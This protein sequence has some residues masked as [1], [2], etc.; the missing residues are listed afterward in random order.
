MT[1]TL[2]C[3]NIA[4]LRERARRRLPRGIWEYLERGVEDEHGMARNRAA[5]DA[6]TFV[7]RVM[8]RVE[9]IDTSASIFGKPVPLPL[10]IAPTGAAGLIWHKGDVHLARAAA[11]A[12]VP[13]TI[14][15][16]GTMDIEEIV[17]AGGTQW[18]Q[19]Y[20][21][22]DKDL[23][24]DVVRR[25]HLLG[26]EA[27]FVT[28]D[29]PVIPNREYLHRNGY[30]MPIK[31]NRRNVPD[32]LLHPRWLAG[33]LGRYLLEDG[34]LPTQANLPA[35]L[36]HS[37]ARG[38]KPGAHFKQDD[39]DEDALRHLRDLWPGKL[40]LKGILHPDDARRALALGAD[41]IV[42][43]NHGGR[44]LDGSIAAIDALPAIVE[45]VT[46]KLTVFLDSGVRR[47]S[48]I[49]KARA[50]GADAVMV[51]R[52][53]LYGLAAAGEA[54]VAR[55]LELLAEE[56]RRTMAMLGARNWDEVSRAT[57]GL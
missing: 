37:V 50:L 32:M 19:L 55:A 24:Y 39:L 17:P 8:R 40:V 57:L 18:F 9:A 26:C 13:F 14:S 21:W 4:D 6:L 41:G 11:A 20:L 33:V 7:P 43:S 56:T 53:A 5:L 47:G 16:A 27:L 29:L 48:D 2:D 51:G 45:A 15:S 49:V 1:A 34:R 12:A 44:A 10:A 35:H 28:L 42:V 36:K 52:A 38:A 46:G 23:S 25:A 22:R 3:W 54:G 31:A 30:G